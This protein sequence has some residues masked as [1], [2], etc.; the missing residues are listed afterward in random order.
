MQNAKKA[1]ASKA[2]NASTTATVKAPLTVPTTHNGQPWP[3][4]SN[5]NFNTALKSFCNKQGIVGFTGALTVAPNTA[6]VN[7]ALPLNNPLPT[8]S[9]ITNGTKRAKAIYFLLFG[10]PLVHNTPNGQPTKTSA[11]QPYSNSHPAYGLL[12]Y[13]CPAQWLQGQ[14]PATGGKAGTVSH[15]LAHCLAANKTAGLTDN[16]SLIVGL[17]LNGGNTGNTTGAPLISL[18]VNAPTVS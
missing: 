13:I 10:T 11:L 14:H 15:N 9:K 4:N 1:T 3:A 2:K 12:G 7:T 17:C 18:T 16:A 8:C 5:S 6:V